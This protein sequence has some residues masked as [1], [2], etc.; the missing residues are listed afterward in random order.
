MND[1]NNTSNQIKRDCN[2]NTMMYSQRQGVSSHPQW[3]RQSN[4]NTKLATPSMLLKGSKQ[5][6]QTRLNNLLFIEKPQRYQGVI[7]TVD[8]CV[9]HQALPFQK[10]EGDEGNLQPKI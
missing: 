1:F 7:L 6:H 8:I 3:N 2:T 9:G 5:P 4:L 10:G